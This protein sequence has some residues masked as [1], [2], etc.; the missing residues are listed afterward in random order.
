MKVTVI[1]F[2]V[3]E[4]VTRVNTRQNVWQKDR[5]RDRKRVSAVRRGLIK[6]MLPNFKNK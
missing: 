3:S 5:E 2:L 1:V 4:I 6:N